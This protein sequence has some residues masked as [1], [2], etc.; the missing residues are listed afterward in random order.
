M[1]TPISTNERL[2]QLVEGAGL[3]QPAAL[4]LFNIGFGIRGIKESTWKG[5]F[6]KPG[7]ARYR[8]FDPALLEHAEKVF[9]PIQRQ[10]KSL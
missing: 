10:D 4:N 2:R 9:G 1:N 7:T 6:C 8:G 3:S 5:Y